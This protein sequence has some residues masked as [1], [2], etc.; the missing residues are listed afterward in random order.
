MIRKLGGKA[1]GIV[2]HVGK[3][4]DRKKLLEFAAQKFGGIDV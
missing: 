1:E 4:E 2:C 3:P